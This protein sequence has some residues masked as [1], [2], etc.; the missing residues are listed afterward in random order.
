MNTLH[1]MEVVMKN[2]KRHTS[3]SMRKIISPKG[4]KITSWGL[5][6]IQ[7]LT[8]LLISA[9]SVARAAEYSNMKAPTLG[10]QSIVDNTANNTIPSLGSDNTASPKSAPA[11]DSTMSDNAMQAGKILSSDN[12]ANSSINYAKSVGED[13]IN[14][15]INDWLNQKGTARVSVESDN[16]IAGICY[17]P[18]LEITTSS[19]L[20]NLECTVMKIEIPLT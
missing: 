8:P 3:I 6:L 4:V 15:Q 2:D 20:R 16:K 17:F 12:I 19:Y 18:S 7:L 14:Q 1:N 11:P 13:L 10:S 9:S 5:I